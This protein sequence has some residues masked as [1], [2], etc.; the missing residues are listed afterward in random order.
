MNGYILQMSGRFST[1]KQC[2]FCRQVTILAEA[3]LPLGSVTLMTRALVIISGARKPFFLRYTYSS[4][5]IGK[6]CCP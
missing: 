6:D 5:S 2:P 1:L 3:V 4:S